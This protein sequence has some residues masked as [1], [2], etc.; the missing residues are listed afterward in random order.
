M[1]R[2][3]S[4]PMLSRRTGQPCL[5][6]SCLTLF[7]LV[8]S[9]SIAAQEPNVKLWEW[10]KG[11]AVESLTQPNMTV[12]LWFY[13]WNMFEARQ[14]G[15]HTSGTYKLKR[16]ISDDRKTASVEAPDMTLSIRA[17]TDGAA[18]SFK[19]T[20]KTDYDWPDIA[21][22]IPCFSP[23][24]PEE[25]Q[26]RFPLA[27]LNSQFDNQN[28]WYIGRNGLLKLERR[29]I[30]F[31]T[32]LRKQVDRA[33]AD[34]KLKF[35]HKW[36]TAKDDAHAGALIRESTDGRW[37]TGIMWEEFL[38]AQG[39]NP[40][41]C[42]HLCVSVGPLTPGESKTI[43]GKIYLFKGTKENCFKRIQ[44]DFALE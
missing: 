6:V 12:Y 34:G 35:S 4:A 37:V 7:C 32:R 17:V 11:F 20:N 24:A 3:L 27:K 43:R 5:L 38:S 15:E 28:T 29:A 40:W 42:M 30:H 2:R 1:K 13:E 16:T 18:L 26:K 10:E 33:S 23:G 41:Q 21:G 36:P 14:K 9:G 25:Q 19:I 44:E 39:H 22:I 31:N 8:G